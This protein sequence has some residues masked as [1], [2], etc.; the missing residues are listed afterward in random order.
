M[1]PIAE[2]FISS[3]LGD[4]PTRGV[5]KSADIGYLIRVGGR[6]DPATGCGSV[7]SGHLRVDPAHRS[8]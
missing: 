6:V 1:A 8:L 7:A 2:I 4:L 3:F 5:V